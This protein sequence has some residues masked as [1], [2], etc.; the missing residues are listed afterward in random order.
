ML[1]VVPTSAGPVEVSR[2][3]R[4]E[5]PAVLFFPGG[6]CSAATDC[7]GDLYTDLGLDVVSFS[8]PGY[9]RTR[10]GAMVAAAFADVVAE[11]RGALGLGRVAAAVG[12]SFGGLQAVQVAAHR[13]IGA[14]RL[15][16][17]SCAPS[18]LAYPD[19]RAEAWLA[20]VV[21]SPLLEGAT[22][23][24][25]RRLVRSDAGLR[26]MLATLSTLPARQW[27]DG[28]GAADRDAARAMFRGMRSRRGFV[29]DLRQARPAAA[30]ARRAALARVECPALITASPTD[31]GVA[32]RHALDH[33]EH[34]RDARLVELDSPTHLCW[35]GPGRPRLAAAVRD[36]LAGAV[37]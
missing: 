14:E 34:L 21:F 28:L 35:I 13:G 31:G 26:R 32:Y 10:V 16:L 7:G 30:A 19:S 17:H 12:V 11:V 6:H 23:W 18:T 25:V 8:R 24:L 20:P 2:T 4:G 22:W 15:V 37:T 29:T 9:G 33:R 3:G 5:R 1:Q 36:F 27:W